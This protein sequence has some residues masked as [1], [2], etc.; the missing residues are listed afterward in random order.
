MNTVKITRI[1]SDKSHAMSLS[2]LRFYGRAY[3]QRKQAVEA[4]AGLYRSSPASQTMLQSRFQISA[5][6][7]TICVLFIHYLANLSRSSGVSIALFERVQTAAN[8]RTA[9]VL[10]AGMVAVPAVLKT[11]CHIELTRLSRWCQLCQCGAVFCTRS[12]ISS[13]S[14]NGVAIQQSCTLALI[15]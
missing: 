10:P 12:H 11:W 7:G 3:W 6:E 1:H 4:F 15:A 14:C 2:L 5:A 8:N 9:L 13:P